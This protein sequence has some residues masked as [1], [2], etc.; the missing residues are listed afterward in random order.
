MDEN[1]RKFDHRIKSPDPH[2]VAMLAAI[3]EIRGAFRVGL[4]MTPQ[5]I[6][7][8]KKSVLIT[9]TGAST[10]IEGAKL[11]DE[12]V[13]KIMQGMAI[14][15]FSDRDSQEV[16]G[17]LE[18]LKNVFGNYKTLPL[19]ESVIASLHKEI[20]KY[21]TKDD[22]H[23]GEYKHKENIVGALGP[24]GTIAT[25]MFE[26]TRAYLT[27]KEMTEL[28]EW[29]RE[30]LEK[31]R[32]HPLLIIA[33]FIIEFLKIHPFE[34]GNG[35]LSRILTN[36]L[37]LHSGYSFVEYV[38]HEQIVEQRKDQYY[39]ALRSSQVTFKTDYETISPWLNF[40][41][42]VVKEQAAKS[43]V[44]LGQ[45][46][47]EDTMS[48]KQIEVLDYL[49][50]VKEAGPSEIVKVTGIIMPTVRKALERLVEIGKVKRIGRGRGT[51]YIKIQAL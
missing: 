28:V 34:D 21:S 18:T 23:R 14:Q 26:T 10:R 19:R 40:F 50:K 1:S 15:K 35:R 31:E 30:G 46:T 8:L 3:D 33:N 9:S 42:S 48:P 25:V 43:F 44:L 39:L 17:Y 51:R 27:P 2:I 4:R 47:H 32:F 7:S 49:S 11:S 41:L 13:K 12:E 22:L 24:D 36:L 37:L 5:A 20:L 16:Q 29:T 45:E 38:S 6:T